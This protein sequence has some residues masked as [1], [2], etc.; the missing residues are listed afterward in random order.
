M[1][2]CI[3]DDICTHDLHNLTMPCVMTPCIIVTVLPSDA[4]V[5][6]DILSQ[7]VIH[8]IVLY[9]NNVMYE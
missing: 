4:M 9:A 7:V 5:C 2:V 8:D 3:L 6:D 1:Y